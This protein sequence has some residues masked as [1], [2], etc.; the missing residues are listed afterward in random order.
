MESSESYM[1]DYQELAELRT[2]VPGRH[3]SL[4]KNWPCFCLDGPIVAVH[5]KPMSLADAGPSYRASW[6]ISL[7]DDGRAGSI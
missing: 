2:F 1:T 6:E 5:K 3:W 7:L 4:A